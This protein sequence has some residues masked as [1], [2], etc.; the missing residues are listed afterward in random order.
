[1]NPHL[2][3]MSD[4]G[5]DAHQ[6]RRNCERSHVEVDNAVLRAQRAGFPDLAA[7]LIEVRT[8]LDIIRKAAE[9]ERRNHTPREFRTIGERRDLEAQQAPTAK[10]G[11]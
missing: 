3:S 2:P 1:M 7:A 9:D 11:A 6:I 10:G 5:H 8:R 4:R